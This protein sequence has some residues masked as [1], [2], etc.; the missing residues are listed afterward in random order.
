MK[1]IVDTH[2]LLW[3]YENNSRLPEKYVVQLQTLEQRNNSVGL[4]DISLWEIA[5]LHELKKLQLQISVDSLLDKIYSESWLKIL[6]ISPEIALES[7]R[8][9]NFHKDPADQLIAAA[10]RV[11]QCPLLT[12]DKKIIDSQAVAIA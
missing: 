8:L 2:I 1:V 11:S 5:K 7:T 6:A 12:V 9:K 3:W 4:C 10:A